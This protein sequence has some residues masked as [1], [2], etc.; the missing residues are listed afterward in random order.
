FRQ[1]DIRLIAYVACGNGRSHPT[2]AAIREEL[3]RVLPAYSVP[4][5][6]IVLNTLPM[7]SSGKVDRS[8]LPAPAEFKNRTQEHRTP[9]G[10]HEHIL[11]AIWSKVLGMPD[12]GVD[13]D[14]FELGGTSLQAFTI[15]AE[16][17]NALDCDLPPTCMMAAP[18]IAKQAVLAWQKISQAP[19]PILV[20]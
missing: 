4:S 2:G 7:T 5:D 10:E 1:D 16:I 15:F 6:I 19:P 20:P 17:A 8:A 11:S 18:T 3:A 14:F 9:K 12:I 13:E